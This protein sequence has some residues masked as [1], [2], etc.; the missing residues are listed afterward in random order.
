[1]RNKYVVVF[2]AFLILVELLVLLGYTGTHH[3]EYAK[4]GYELGEAK[5]M[6]EIFISNVV[7]LATSI[8]VT[9]QILGL[10]LLYYWLNKKT[11]SD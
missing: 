8:I 11:E 3:F 5:A 9:V 7:L 6:L 10:V 1:M 2:L 4:Y